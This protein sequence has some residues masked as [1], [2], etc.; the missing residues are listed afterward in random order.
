MKKS[1]RRGSKPPAPLPPEPIYEN[2]KS[3]DIQ[4]SFESQ[5]SLADKPNVYKKRAPPAVPPLEQPNSWGK[6]KPAPQPSDARKFESNGA[7]NGSDKIKPKLNP[8]REMQLIGKNKS[9]EVCT[10]EPTMTQHLILHIQPCTLQSEDEAPFNFQGMLRKTKHNRAS[11][12]RYGSNQDQ[13]EDRERNIV[14][15]EL[16]NNSS[17]RVEEAKMRYSP[18]KPSN[19]IYQSNKSTNERISTVYGSSKQDDCVNRNSIPSIT[20]NGGEVGVYIQEEIH[21]GIILEGYAVEI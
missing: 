16:N 20:R 4:N 15:F 7:L 3:Q 14:T 12:K 10:H 11:M 21:P 18:L 9:L 13:L 2:L 17:S 1:L 19:L 6:K 5:E 8:V